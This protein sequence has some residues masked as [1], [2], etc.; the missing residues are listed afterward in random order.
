MGQRGFARMIGMDESNY[1]G[2]ETGRLI[3]G[4]DF[5]DLFVEACKLS[6]IEKE[7][8]LSL[9]AHD[10]LLRQVIQEDER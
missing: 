3:P 2:Y 8:I 6:E 7:L 4:D 1:N 9:R 10:R 5:I